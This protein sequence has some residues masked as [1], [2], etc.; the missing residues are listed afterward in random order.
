MFEENPDE[1]YQSVSQLKADLELLLLANNEEWTES[2]KAFQEITPLSKRRFGLYPLSS[3]FIL[4][5]ALTLIL[6]GVPIFGSL[7]V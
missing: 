6:T 5:G 7:P 1:R 2:A 4:F 3:E